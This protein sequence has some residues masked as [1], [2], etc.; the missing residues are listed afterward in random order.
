MP[1]APAVCVSARRDSAEAGAA[2]LRSGGNAFDAIAAAGFMDA[3]IAPA[4]CGIGGY[5][6]TGI[7]YLARAGRMVALDANAVAPAAATPGMFPVVPGRDPNRYSFPD[8]RHKLGP[9]SVAVPGVLAGLI[10]LQAN[11]GRLDRKAVIAPA[12]ER[13]RKGVALT[14]AVALTWMT[15]EE[16]TDHRPAP[17]NA[18]VPKRVRMPELADT[19]EAIASEGQGVFY[20]GR[21]GRAIAEQ[22]RSLGGILTPED[23]AA[24][25]AVVVKPVQVEVRGL[26][27]ATPPPATGGLSALQMVALF[28]RLARAGRPGE[29]ATAGMYEALIEIDKVVWEERLTVLADTRSMTVPPESLLKADHLD[30]LLERV[31]AGLDQPGPGRVVAE[32]PLRGTSHLVAADAEGNVVSWTQTQGGVFGS[33]V[34]VKGTGV[35]LGHGMCRFEPRPGWA[36][37]IAPGKRPLHNMC[38]VIAVKG[39]RAVLAL[40]ASGGRTIV[41]NVAAVTINRLLLGL[42]PAAAVAAPRLQCETIEPVVL[43]RA[44][45]EAVFEALKRRGHAVKPLNLDAG[46]VELVACDPDGSGWVGAAEP[47]VATAATVPA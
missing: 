46:S 45:G 13:A 36:N 16:A 34:M 7:G 44:A 14:P 37:S 1:P 42:E 19:L 3:V 38:P 12:I 9:L 40:G 35:V 22:V 33:R 24:Y 18:A 20:E 25:R 30:A 32:D 4:M 31:V 6:A 27:L 5:A 11:W 26:T 17:P 15:M 29:A 10:T 41:N 8:T 43:E 39:G 2:V 47:R 23:L 21:I 28:D